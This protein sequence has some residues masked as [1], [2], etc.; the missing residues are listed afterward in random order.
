M[1]LDIPPH[2]FDEAQDN[3]LKSGGRLW[4]PR[5][6]SAL[7]TLSI[8]EKDVTSG[9][10]PQNIHIAIGIRLRMIQGIMVPFYAGNEPMSK[11]FAKGLNWKT[12]YPKQESDKECILWE[13]GEL[14]NVKCAG[15]SG[16]KYKEM[17][18]TEA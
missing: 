8:L 11:L 12:G 16:G 5:S 10:V 13:D 6:E 4:Q 14:K 9:N 7:E 3:C 2:N 1:N 17:T 18:K 15:F